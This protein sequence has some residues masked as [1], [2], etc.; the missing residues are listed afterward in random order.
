[1]GGCYSLQKTSVYSLLSGM[2]GFVLTGQCEQAVAQQYKHGG[3]DA[4]V[5]IPVVR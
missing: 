1:M 3:H 2:Q 5:F 4:S